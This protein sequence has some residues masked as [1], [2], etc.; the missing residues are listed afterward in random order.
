MAQVASEA[1]QSFL[2]DYWKVVETRPKGYLRLRSVMS[3]IDTEDPEAVLLRTLEDITDAESSRFLSGRSASY[4]TLMLGVGLWL[5]RPRG[6]NILG[7]D[8]TA[9][10][11]G[12]MSA[13]VKELE[14]DLVANRDHLRRSQSRPSP[15]PARL[16]PTPVRSVHDSVHDDSDKDQDNATSVDVPPKVDTFLAQVSAYRTPDDCR[17]FMSESV[18]LNP[19]K[20]KN[21]DPGLLS[22]QLERFFLAEAGSRGSFSVVADLRRRVGPGGTLHRIVETFYAEMLRCDQSNIPFPMHFHSL[23]DAELS[24]CQRL[25]N[26]AKGGPRYAERIEAEYKAQDVDIP[27]W[28]KAK[29]RTDAK[30]SKDFQSS[31]Q[32]GASGGRGQGTSTFGSRGRGRGRGRGNRGGNQQPRGRGN[33]APQAQSEED[34]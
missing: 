17:A 32:T 7:E 28:R 3:K 10:D 20:W 25:A 27:I 30:A 9:T 11:R 13:R 24:Q 8:E 22:M 1:L 16:A 34:E 23:V 21:V 4:E 2:R 14:A 18:L 26:V 31:P 29:L 19:S 15:D 33:I 6:A 12:L 5:D